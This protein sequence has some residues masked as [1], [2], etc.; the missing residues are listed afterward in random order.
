[1]FSDTTDILYNDVLNKISMCKIFSDDKQLNTFIFSWSSH[2]KI[3]N[4]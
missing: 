1:M 2:H 4:R 3:S